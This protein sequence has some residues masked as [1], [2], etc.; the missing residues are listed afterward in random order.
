[1]RDGTEMGFAELQDEVKTA[2]DDAG[3]SYAEVARE[4]DVHRTS[5]ARAANEPGAKYQDLQQ[6]IIELLTPYRIERRVVFKAHRDD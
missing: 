3:K 5:V 1:M 6:R 4:L 2:I